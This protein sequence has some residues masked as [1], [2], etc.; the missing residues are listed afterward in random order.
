MT[1]SLNVDATKFRGHL[2]SVMN[3]YASAGAELV[4]VIKGNGYGFG[5]G[6]LADE[7]SRLGCNRIAIGTI[8]ELGQALADF[9]GEITQLM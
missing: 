3:S 6:V 1:F 2:V 8:W 4:P 9:P 5:R 7:A